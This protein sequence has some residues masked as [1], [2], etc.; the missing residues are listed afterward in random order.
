MLSL[1]CSPIGPCESLFPRA[2]SWCSCNGYQVS[3]NPNHN[4][5]GLT[6]GGPIF[7]FRVIGENSV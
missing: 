3:S 2:R 5:R 1:D 4:P 6:E 7:F